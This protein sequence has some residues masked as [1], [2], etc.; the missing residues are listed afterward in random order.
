[1]YFLPVL[2]EIQSRDRLLPL[3]VRRPLVAS[4]GSHAE[5]GGLVCRAGGRPHHQGQPLA[6]MDLMKI[7]ARLP[8]RLTAWSWAAV[9]RVTRWQKA[10]NC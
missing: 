4:G 3:P 10:K 6:V 1:M 5:Q 8:H 7:D 2:L 9:C